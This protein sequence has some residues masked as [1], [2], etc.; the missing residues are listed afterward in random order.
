MWICATSDAKQIT[1]KDCFACCFKPSQEGTILGIYQKRVF[2]LQLSKSF[3][4]QHT[5][6]C[7][8]LQSKRKGN[9]YRFVHFQTFHVELKIRFVAVVIGNI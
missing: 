1:Q 5:C 2:Y 9:R 8:V 7:S 4:R 3:T 6:L